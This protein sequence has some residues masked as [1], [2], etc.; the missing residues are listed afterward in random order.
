GLTTI[1]PIVEGGDV[2]LGVEFFVDGLSLWTDFIPPYSYVIN[3]ASY[4]D[5][6]HTITVYTADNTG[7]FASDE[8][9]VTFDNSPPV[10][11]K[12][13]PA[14]GVAVFYEDRPLTMELETDDVNSMDLVK[15]RAAGF[16]VGE[17]FNPPFFV[18]KAWDEIYVFEDQLP[19]T[20]NVR[21]FARDQLGLETEVTYNVEVH[22]RF[23]WQY[24]NLVQVWSPAVAFS[25][26]NVAY[27][28][29]GETSGSFRVLNPDGEL[30]CEMDLGAF[31]AVRT[32]VVY[33]P[34]N[35]RVL[36]T[37][38]QAHLRAFDSNCGE[39]WNIDHE[40]TAASL[41][42]HGSEVYVLS[43]YG[44]VKVYNTANGDFHWS[45][46]AQTGGDQVFS[47][48]AVGA[49]GWAYFGDDGGDFF[50]VSKEAS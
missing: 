15:L 47:R 21:F 19:T 37:T 17:F 26:G 13:I 48:V 7:Q 10:F 44:T 34:S 49:N 42:V 6:P 12:T 4:A 32:P 35:D 27:A 5:G 31:G 14:E 24:E 20:V 33:D 1:Q 25:N 45:G 36:L 50:A 38:L 16:L 2:I 29:A 46:N 40:H 39:A 30:V 23:G 28:T 41:A 18:Q 3:T 9:I 11:T 8:T 22:R 43:I